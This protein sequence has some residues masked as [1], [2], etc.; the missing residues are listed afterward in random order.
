MASISSPTTRP[1]PLSAL[2]A[3][4]K[5]WNDAREWLIEAD[6]AFQNECDRLNAEDQ[7]PFIRDFDYDLWQ[8]FQEKFANGEIS[9]AAQVMKIL[10][11]N[12]TSPPPIL[13]EVR[14]AIIRNT[15]VFQYC[16]DVAITRNRLLQ[17]S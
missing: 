17:H 12:A 7:A 10:D 14:N 2:T 15:A 3:D 16:E 5:R 6:R 13:T 8:F 1:L 4:A 9:F 11:P